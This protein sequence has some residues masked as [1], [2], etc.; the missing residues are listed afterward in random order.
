VAHS[1]KPGPIVLS[2]LAIVMLI[3]GCGGDGLDLVSNG[4]NP[5]AAA[6]GSP[7]DLR[8][9]CPTTVVVQTG[10]WPDITYG[11]LYQMVA[12][13]YAVDADQKRVSGP[14]VDRGVDTG[15]KLEIR[16]GG[17]AVAFQ[18]TASVM[19]LDRA[20]TLGQQATEEQI[21]VA[22]KVSTVAVMAPLALDPVAFLYDAQQHPDWKTLAD[23]G[24]SGVRVFSAESASIRYLV[25][26]GILS[27][28]QVDMSFTGGPD[29]MVQTDYKAAVGGFSTGD[30]WTYEHLEGVET[31]KLAY[32]YVAN[33]RGP[34]SYPNYR[35]QIT[36]L[37]E[38]R[39]ELALCLKRLIPVMQRAAVDFMRDPGSVNAMIARITR[40]FNAPTGHTVDKGMYGLGVMRTDRIVADGPSGFL[41]EIDPQRVANV[42][43]QLR[44][45]FKPPA[46][47]TAEQ[48]AT[49]EYL[50]RSIKLSQ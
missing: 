12:G 35:N 16:P 2:V 39:A 32:A 6:P 26:S 41:G 11:H 27:K 3:A 7:Q 19:Q 10:W 18:P 40:D 44:P 34:Q 15:V 17:P 13:T 8:S 9:V 4:A 36:V 5:T 29:L 14:L 45:I 25:G 33:A 1:R 20:I 48:L 21:D 24:R 47:L 50:D 37:S 43:D 28:A 49:N 42:L 30:P 31:R 38:R 23:I 22:P 46:G